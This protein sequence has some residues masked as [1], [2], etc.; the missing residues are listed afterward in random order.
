MV[1]TED[2]ITNPKNMAR[3][4]NQ[5]SNETSFA[6]ITKMTSQIIQPLKLIRV[7]EFQLIITMLMTKIKYAGDIC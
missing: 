6:S 5:K 1:S 3:V 2:Y 4:K 7:S